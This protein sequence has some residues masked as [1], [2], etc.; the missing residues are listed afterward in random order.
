[1]DYYNKPE[2]FYCRQCLH[3]VIFFFF[4]TINHDCLIFF[5]YTVDNESPI[6]LILDELRRWLSEMV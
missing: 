6:M 4:F 2:Y 1:M 3:L 5:D